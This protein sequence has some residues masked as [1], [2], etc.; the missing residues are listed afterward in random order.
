MT[1]NQSKAVIPVRKPTKGPRKKRARPERREFTVADLE[2]AR[3]RPRRSRG[4][5][6]RQR[7]QPQSRKGTPRLERTQLELSV[8]ES[9]LQLRCLLER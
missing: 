2:R 5:A 9:Q 7:A 8:I 4:A 6:N 3:T 1:R